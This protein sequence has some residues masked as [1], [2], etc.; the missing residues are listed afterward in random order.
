M[1]AAATRADSQKGFGDNGYFDDQN[2]RL[3]DGFSF[4]CHF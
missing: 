3:K 2:L 1:T 4:F